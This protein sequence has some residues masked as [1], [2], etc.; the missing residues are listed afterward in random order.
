MIRTVM[1]N[2]LVLFAVGVALV[3]GALRLWALDLSQFQDIDDVRDWRRTGALLDGKAPWWL[4]PDAAIGTGQGARL[5]GGLYYLLLSAAYQFDAS[6]L[7]GLALIALTGTAAAVLTIFA[8]RTILSPR[9]CLM[10]GILAATSPVWVLGSRRIWNPN[11]LPL[12][13]VI[14]FWAIALW[15]SQRS[16]VG[17]FLAFVVFGLLLQLHLSALALLPILAVALLR[18]IR[19]PHLLIVAALLA[20]IPL[21][22]FLAHDAGGGWRETERLWKTLSR[23]LIDREPSKD[24]ALPFPVCWPLPYLPPLGSCGYSDDTLDRTS[25]ALLA[26]NAPSLR[27][28]ETLDLYWKT[29]RG[30][31]LRSARL[32][33]LPEKISPA[34]RRRIEEYRTGKEV[35]YVG[36]W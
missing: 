23:V 36:M 34:T 21:L 29:G 19:R 5:P 1:A 26:Q 20:I 33:D 17:L 7:S 32:E 13:S 4:G 15:F 31:L 28:S 3:G 27:E 24:Q 16:R 18:V 14:F 22:P 2:R 30:R 12:F 9:A 10:A 8:G 11:L 35:P 25:A 6:P